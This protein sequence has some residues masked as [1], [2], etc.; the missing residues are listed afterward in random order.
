MMKEK[1]NKP[2]SM[3]EE[4]DDERERRQAIFLWKK[5][6]TIKE[7]EDKPFSMEEEGDDE[8]ER[9]QA[10]LYGRKRRR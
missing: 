10:I 1:E 3:E 9:K 2:L 8:R 5:K 7:K 4:G 6:K